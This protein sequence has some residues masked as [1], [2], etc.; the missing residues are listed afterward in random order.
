[1]RPVT[2][3]TKPTSIPEA[4]ISRTAM[5]L[6]HKWKSAVHTKADERHD[7]RRD[8]GSGTD[9]ADGGFGHP[10]ELILASAG[11]RTQAKNGRSPGGIRTRDLSLERAAS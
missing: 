9:S 3:S 4:R 2:N 1:M 11:L 5:G 7:H 6:V 10:R 8:S